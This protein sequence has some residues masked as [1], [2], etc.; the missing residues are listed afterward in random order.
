[1]KHM[2]QAPSD[3]QFMATH[4]VLN[5]SPSI[6]K[7]K[8]SAV[9]LTACC[10]VFVSFASVVVYTFGVFLK[11]LASSFGWSRTE[12]SLAFT[13][14]ALTVAACSPFI[15]RLLDRF[16]ARRLVLPCT[17]IYAAAFGSLAFLTSL[18]SSCLALSATA[19]HSWAMHASSAPR[20]TT[21]EVA[22]WP[23]LWLDQDSARW[24]SPQRR[25]RSSL[26]WLACSVCGAGS[27][28]SRHSCP[29]RHVVPVRTSRDSWSVARNQ[30]RDSW[31]RSLLT[32]I[33]GNL[34]RP[35]AL[36]LRDKWVEHTLGS[37]AD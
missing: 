17:V 2:P 20:S 13:L 34:S 10:G 36:F 3:P 37:A 16:P 31:S 9:L 22:R 11:P 1:M 26:L 25:R 12:V 29:P 30:R 32:T 5:P 7:S 15:G 21:S 35:T 24:Y 23:P 4:A 6:Q 28:H 8:R 19:R 33:P 14:A 27:N 18:Y